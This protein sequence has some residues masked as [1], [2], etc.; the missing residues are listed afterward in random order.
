MQTTLCH[1]FPFLFKSVLEA[2]FELNHSQFCLC[3]ETKAK[4]LICRDHEVE[5]TV[6]EEQ[7][8]REQNL[9]PSDLVTPVQVRV[10]DQVAHQLRKIVL[11]I[12]PVQVERSFVNDSVFV[13]VEYL[14]LASDAAFLLAVEV[15][16]SLR[17]IASVCSV[18][19]QAHIFYFT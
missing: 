14:L 19:G 10:C 18:L 11:E 16:D 2:L 13:C 17:L 12:R 9:K 3:V 5:L 1:F 6:L 15:S 7:G 8:F 4:V